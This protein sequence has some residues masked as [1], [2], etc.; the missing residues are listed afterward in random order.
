MHPV[1]GVLGQWRWPKN[2]DTIWYSKNPDTI[3]YSKIKR[4]IRPP[5]PVAMGNKRSGNNFKFEDDV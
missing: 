4:K 3:W 5:H 2:P 1:P